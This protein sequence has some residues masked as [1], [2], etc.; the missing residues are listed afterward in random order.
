MNTKTPEAVASNA[1]LGPVTDAD[2]EV[3]IQKAGALWNG[4]YWKIEDADMHPMA[5]A[6]MA[7][8]RERILRRGNKYVENMLIGGD[9]A[10]ALRGFLLA[11][12]AESVPNTEAMR[13]AAKD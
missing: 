10:Y 13:H 12:G 9:K 4:S 5:R 8:E 11:L 1:E 7:T 2:I 6:L 3:L